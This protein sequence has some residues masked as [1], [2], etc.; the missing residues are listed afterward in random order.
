MT[1][2]QERTPNHLLAAVSRR[3]YREML[4]GLEEDKAGDFSKLSQGRFEWSRLVAALKRKDTS[5]LSE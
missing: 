3:A 4:S 5:L 1:I 2:A